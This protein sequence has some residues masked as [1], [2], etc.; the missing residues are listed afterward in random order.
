MASP[1]RYIA[2]KFHAGGL[3][4]SIFTLIAAT[5]G[6]G[7]LTMPYAV[8]LNGYVLG[9]ILMALGALVSYY[10]GMLIV[11]QTS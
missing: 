8:S 4:G 11:S 6:A 9:P 2:R 1:G 7:T 10:S 5:L 3:K